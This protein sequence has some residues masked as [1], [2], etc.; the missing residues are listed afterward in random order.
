M[1]LGIA[2]C[3]FAPVLTAAQNAHNV[4]PSAAAQNCAALA[5][6]NL[7]TAPGGPAIITSARL[8]DV[9]TNGLEQWIVVPSGYGSIDA[10]IVSRI[11]EYCDVTG[12][13]APQNKF[14]L[15]LPLPGDWNQKFFF[16]AC[17]GFCGSVDGRRCNLTL[18]RGY[19]S[20]TGNGGHDSVLGFDGVW[21][22]NAPELQEDF[23][24][25]SN[26]VITLIAKAIIT[27]YYGK[28]IKY[29]YMA[30]NSK[31][32]QAVLMEA[33]R[34]PEDFDGLMPSA[35]VY[36]Y[37]GRNTIAAAW[38]AQGISDGHG[39][40]VL[41]AAAVQ[42]VHKSVLEHCSAQAGV[43]EGLVT[44]PLSCRWQPEMVGCAPETSGPDCLNAKQ[45][46]A[47]EH[48][49]APATDSKGE[50]LYA[51]P[52][53]PGTETQWEGWNYFG[54]PS[55]GY[56]PRFANMELPGQ[57]LKY[58]ADEKIRENVDVL[59]FDFDRDPPTLV[60]ARKIYDANSLDLH[61]FKALGGKILMWHGWADG[62][63]MAT[64]SIGYYEGVIKAM[65]G[66][67]QTEDFFR[68]F[69]VPGV[70][71]GGGGP[72]LTVFD[73]MTALESWVEQGGHPKS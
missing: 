44:D 4:P 15:K 56:P 53:I 31:G 40:S 29:S 58:L 35:P 21:A 3:L 65:G 59:K 71:H 26:H 47:I 24:W 2:L 10:Q 20:V 16:T 42:V 32:G 46:A 7:E 70:H 54:A 48:L 66:R 22:A 8:V 64:S 36:D 73:S 6:L 41:N 34:F 39:G 1:A 17:G 55:P 72:G 45:V 28:P 19:A 43:E 52:Y 69:L 60:R 38:L 30:G 27:R 5:S 12:Y 68:L 67:K 23:G 62:A 61:A 57:Y 18:A 33:Q 9:P 14:E 63:V 51:Y 50:V 11:H 37:T 25:R 49:M 13:V